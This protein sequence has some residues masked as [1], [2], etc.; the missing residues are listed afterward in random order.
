VGETL[1]ARHYANRDLV[2]RYRRDTPG[3]GDSG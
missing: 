1:S 2:E 3:C